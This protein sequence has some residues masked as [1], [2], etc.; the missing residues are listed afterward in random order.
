MARPQA[1]L[2]RSGGWSAQSAHRMHVIFQGMQARKVAEM[3]CICSAPKCTPG[4]DRQR[5]KNERG[6]GH[7]ESR[8][9]SSSYFSTPTIVLG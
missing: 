7:V 5:R 8:A 4:F 9:V 2:L 6:A 1:S 3:E